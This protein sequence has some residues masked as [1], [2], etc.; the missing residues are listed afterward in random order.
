MD[1]KTSKWAASRTDVPDCVDGWPAA[2]FLYVALFATPTSY[3]PAFPTSSIY[4][5]EIGKVSQ[6][7]NGA[8]FLC[9][10]RF[11]VSTDSNP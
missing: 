8:Q 5:P 9:Y 4:L 6:Y 1:E 10:W 3:D 11:L 7:I 2:R